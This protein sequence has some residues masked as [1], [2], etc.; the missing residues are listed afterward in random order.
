MTYYY[1]Y[2]IENDPPKHVKKKKGTN[3]T[4]LH[5]PQ[6]KEI[7]LAMTMATTRTITITVMIAVISVQYCE[8]HTTF[9]CKW[10][11]Q[12]DTIPRVTKYNP[13]LSSTTLWELHS[14]SL[15]LHLHPQYEDGQDNHIPVLD[16]ESYAW[17]P[18]GTCGVPFR[19]RGCSLLH[20]AVE[21]VVC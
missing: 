11:C 5:P 18:A 3:S 16:T 20:K 10:R 1:F 6:T 4:K 7:P 8:H 17:S 19:K 13:P 21:P 12:N 14:R 2:L 15:H 9:F